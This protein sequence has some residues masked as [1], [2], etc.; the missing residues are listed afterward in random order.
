V[1]AGN[2]KGG[3]IIV[4]LISCFASMDFTVFQIKTKII[5]CH[6]ADSKPVKQEV[7]GRVI[8]PP[9]V[10]PGGGDVLSATQGTLSK[11]EGS[12]QLTFLL[13]RD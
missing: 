1:V 3:S 12:V 5:R 10:F 2:T 4:P 8:R 13:K 9:L 7:N 11:G 6:I